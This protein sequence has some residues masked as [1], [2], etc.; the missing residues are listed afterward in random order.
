MDIYWKNLEIK[1]KENEEEWERGEW[2]EQ[3]GEKM[4]RICQSQ[5]LST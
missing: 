4:R 3:L 2:R 1:E 5:K